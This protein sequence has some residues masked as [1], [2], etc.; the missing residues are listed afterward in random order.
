METRITLRCSPCTPT[1]SGTDKG[2]GVSA[3]ASSREPVCTLG[4][5]LGGT[6][7]KG[8]I[9]STSGELVYSLQVESHLHTQPIWIADRM[10]SVVEA[11][12][13]EA[14][15]QGLQVV[16]IGLSS[17]LDVDPEGGQ[18]LQVQ[19]PHLERWVGFPIASFLSERCSLPTLVENDGIAA[20]WGEYRA[21]AG[22]GSDSL[23]LV[24]L[25]TGIGGG[26]I[27]EG[28]RLPDTLGSGAYFGHMSI[29]M[30]G[31]ECPCGRR[32]CWEMYASARALEGRA[33]R[34]R[35]DWSSPTSLSTYPTGKE[36][37]DA[38]RQNDSLACQLLEEH[39]RL[40]GVGLVNLANLFNPHRIV[41]GGGL[42]LAGELILG[43]A[44][45]TLQSERL[46]LR[47][48][49]ALLPARYPFEAGLI[50]AALLAWEKF[51]ET[52][53]SEPIPDDPERGE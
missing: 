12:K 13:T 47:G 10:A 39:S 50:G 48:G 35:S 36:V 41:V 51:R 19:Y 17:T 26:V 46:P 42:S 53:R 32:G 38:A 29:Q 21:G 40:L 14:A 27:L 22:E 28:Q 16:G 23:L 45:Q 3:G 4:L 30:D 44:R 33:A 25:G 11:L 34:A 52:V 8:G 6:T 15:A 24:T 7:L 2:Q 37:I 1:V 9:L 31:L 43:P 18:F 5:D 49:L 20:A